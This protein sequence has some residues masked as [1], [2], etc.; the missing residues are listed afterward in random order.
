MWEKA[1]LLVLGGFGVIGVITLGVAALALLCYPLVRLALFLVGSYYCLNGWTGLV[2]GLGMFVVLE[3]ILL[4]LAEY[5]DTKARQDI[6]NNEEPN[7]EAEFGKAM[8]DR[9][10]A[11]ALY[12]KNQL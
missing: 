3:F 6:S 12:H 5:L 10:K 1:L 7:L 8:R 4:G 2:F 9:Q 11:L